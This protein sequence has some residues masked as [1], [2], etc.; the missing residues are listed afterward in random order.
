VRLQVDIGAATD[1][2]AFVSPRLE[3][4]RVGPTA[5]LLSGDPSELALGL[6]HFW[7]PK[8]RGHRIDGS[9]KPPLSEES[10]D[11]PEGCV[12]VVDKHGVEHGPHCEE[13]DMRDWI[14]DKLN[15]ID[16]QGEP[17]RRVGLAT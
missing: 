15:L 2:G 1:L 14:E 8:G 5:L 4:R 11:V 7:R 3:V 9:K 6:W 10:S 13:S 16:I 12:T 17:P